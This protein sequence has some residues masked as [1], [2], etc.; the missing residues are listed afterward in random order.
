MDFGTTKN[1][2][3]HYENTVHKFKELVAKKKEMEET[4]HPSMVKDYK[5][6]KSNMVECAVELLRLGVSKHLDPNNVYLTVDDE[7]YDITRDDILKVINKKQWDEI[8]PE[9]SMQVIKAEIDMGTSEAEDNSEEDSV[10][11]TVSEQ[12]V[13]DNTNPFAA[14]FSAMFAPMFNAAGISQ[15]GFD[16]NEFALS[17]QN[18]FKPQKQLTVSEEVGTIQDRVIKLEKERDDAVKHTAFYIEKVE[19][20]E[21]EA[22][23]LKESFDERIKDKTHDLNSQIAKAK[24]DTDKQRKSCENAY[25]ER[26]ALQEELKSLKAEFEKQSKESAKALESLRAENQKKVERLMADLKSA[27]SEL[28]S[29]KNDVETRSKKFDELQA[30]FEAEKKDTSEIDKIVKEYKEKLDESNKTIADFKKKAEEAKNLKDELKIVKK[31]VEGLSELAYF[32]KKIGILNANAFNRDFSKVDYRKV[33]LVITGIR[34]MKSVNEKYGRTSGDSLIKVAAKCCTEVF[35]TENVYRVFG[36][37]FAIITD[38]NE[39]EVAELMKNIKN[40]LEAQEISM[41]YGISIGKVASGAAGMVQSAESSMNAMKNATSSAPTE[42]K[43]DNI[44]EMKKPEKK[45]PVNAEPEE[46]AVDDLIAEY[47]ATEN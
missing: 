3:E 34:N 35:G 4:F 13:A 8:F 1:P 6:T 17:I 10:Q 12:A 11:E 27:E 41:V 45:A 32:D 9:D 37:E 22:K 5:D 39:K 23:A 43:K 21:K 14:L 47:M 16:A 15:Q 29:A 28:K 30:K 44:V 33:N 19:S 7:E 24:A 26:D 46:V 36:D 31:D 18:A 20:L 40:T 25:K 42:S 38:K 2:Y